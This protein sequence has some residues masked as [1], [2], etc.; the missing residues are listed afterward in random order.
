MTG[1]GA[2]AIP[3]GS[4]GRSIGDTSTMWK[5]HPGDDHAG[6]DVNQR[7]RGPGHHDARAI[8]AVNAARAANRA[9]DKAETHDVFGEEKSGQ[10]LLPKI[11]TE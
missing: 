11:D 4:A 2:V 6:Q 3:V 1:A 9:H 8:D 7:N 5:A 10:M